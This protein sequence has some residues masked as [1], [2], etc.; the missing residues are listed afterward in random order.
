VHRR[1]Y[2]LGVTYER[3]PVC[4]LALTIGARIE[5]LRLEQKAPATDFAPLVEVS[6]RG[7]LAVE[8]GERSASLALVERAADALG[9]PAV[10]L[11]VDRGDER[12]V[13]WLAMALVLAVGSE[14]AAVAV[15]RAGALSPAGCPELGQLD[16]VELG[17]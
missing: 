9:V 10:A 5:A 16:A 8:R 7:L 4:A 2:H 1:F 12:T 15:A 6:R 13:E 14:A 3:P 17:G 11:L